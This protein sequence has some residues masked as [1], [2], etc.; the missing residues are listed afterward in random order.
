MRQIF[1]LIAAGALAFPL[2]LASCGTKRTVEGGGTDAAP[3]VAAPSQA[4]KTAFLRKV[5]DNAVY[6]KNITSKID[7]TLQAGDKD[8]SVS[9]SIRMRKDDVIRIQLTPLGLMEVGRIEFTKDYVMIVDR[10][11]KEYVKADYSQLDFLK[12][13]GLDFYTL[14][15]L[16]WNELFLPGAQKVRDSALGSYGLDMSGGTG[17]WPVTYSRGNMSFEWKADS[18]SGLIQSVDVL[19][20]SGQHG[21]TRV[22]CNYSNFKPLGVKQFPATLEMSV[23]TAATRKARDAKVRIQMRGLGTDSDWEPRT[24][25]S[26][27]YKQVD[28]NVLLKTLMSL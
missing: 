20:S 15:A 14:Q 2:L 4:M 9:G 25:V 13:N 11:N 17:S 24:T 23:R 21:D 27:K 16:F 26:G 10:I 1:R 6:S 5:A 12:R 7:F 28:A 3:A 18:K 22:S 19:Y 8:I